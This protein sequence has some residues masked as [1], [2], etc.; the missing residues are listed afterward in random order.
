MATKKIST[1]MN[2]IAVA[3]EGSS[4]IMIQVTLEGLWPG[5]KNHRRSGKTNPN[6][7]IQGN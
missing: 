3:Y 4:V 5:V 2:K 6:A 7:Q 1:P